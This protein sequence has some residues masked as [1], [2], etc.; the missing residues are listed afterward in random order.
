MPMARI[1]DGLGGHEAPVAQQLHETVPTC[2]LHVPDRG[3]KLTVQDMHLARVVGADGLG[4][5][6]GPVAQLPVGQ[7]APDDAP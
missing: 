6:E 1:A 7:I 2:C 4:G 3:L 5:H